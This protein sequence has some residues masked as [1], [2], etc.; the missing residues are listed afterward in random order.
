MTGWN[1][2]IGD[3]T[4]IDPVSAQFLD[5]MR[6]LADFDAP[7]PS[8]ELEQLFASSLPLARRGRVEPAHGAR[9]GGSDGSGAYRHPLLTAAA[10]VVA[11]LALLIAGAAAHRLPAYAQRLVSNVVNN[12]TPF[13]ID[14]VRAPAPQPSHAPSPGG[15][16]QGHRSPT[17]VTGSPSAPRPTTGVP[18]SSN[19]VVPPVRSGA[20][21]TAPNVTS[22]PESAGRST[23][24]TP[25]RATGS[26]SG[27][28]S[29]NTPSNPP[30]KALGRG[31]TG[32]PAAP[33][34]TKG[35]PGPGRGTGTGA[36]GG[37]P[38]P[39]ASVPAG[40][41]GGNGTGTGSGQG[42]GQGS[43]K[44]SGSGGGG[45]GG[46]GG[47]HS[48]SASVHVRLEVGVAEASVGVA[49][50]GQGGEVVQARVGRTHVRGVHREHLAPVRPRVER[51]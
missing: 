43:G 25:S 38:A 8:D 2:H 27:A 11:A 48:G 16:R 45:G 46:G 13:H 20:R 47:G 10:A 3:M 9:L 15:P 40:H 5:E 19:G 18:G 26:P 14:P 28:A 12:F 17:A 31:H 49:P 35:V 34:L 1:D 30:G 29:T 36:G 33:G 22:S 37:R 51:G 39:S 42:S 44:G 23:S 4:A 24:G 50:G 32:H 41:R 7:A 6:A 21:T